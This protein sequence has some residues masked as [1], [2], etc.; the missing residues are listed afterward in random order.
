MNDKLTYNPILVTGVERS[1]STIIARILDMCG[2][3]KGLCNNMLENTI[4]HSLH[5][6]EL[7]QQYIFPE[8][9]SIPIPANWNK[10]I[11][12]Q[13]ENEGWDKS[14]Q[15]MVKGS[16]LSK[17]WHVWDYAFPNAKWLI[18]RRRTG[19]IIQSCIKTGYMR[20]FKDANTLQLLNLENEADGW[21]WW[22][23]QY[24]TKFVEMIQQGLNCRVVWPER[25]VTGNFE[26]MYETIK[27]LGL[28]WN[29]NIPEVI[30]PLLDKGR[31]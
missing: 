30:K 7:P 27:W 4:I 2:V 24:E 15:W 31:R 14:Q 10:L 20:R 18:V 22:V 11:V 28:D 6:E 17:Y 9:K 1:G 5:Y 12:N 8:T 21:L 23:R 29:K 13:I 16:F 25:M 3:W 26:Q 19:D